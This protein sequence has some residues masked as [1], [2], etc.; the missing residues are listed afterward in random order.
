M[1]LSRKSKIT[2]R[3]GQ[4][5]S[6]QGRGVFRRQENGT[7]SARNVQTQAAE[8]SQPVVGAPGPFRR[9][10]G[11]SRQIDGVAVDL[12]LPARTQEQ[13]TLPGWPS[14]G[15]VGVSPA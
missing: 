9:E 5:P 4:L 11:K 6:P 14:Q 3:G 7:R 15:L 12:R 8:T 2:K 13:A 10:Q 1:R